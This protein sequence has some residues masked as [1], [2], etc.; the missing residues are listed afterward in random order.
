MPKLTKT[1]HTDLL[2]RIME[3]GGPTEDMEEL[4]KKLQDD[5]DER[6]GELQRYGEKADKTNPRDTEDSKTERNQKDAKR[7][8]RR[9][10]E[11]EE[12]YNELYN[13]HQN[14]R[15]KYIDRYFTSADKIVED[16]IEDVKK[17]D[18]STKVSFDELF[19]ERQKA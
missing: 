12:K 4:I 3:T 14:L 18:D 11:W 6:E 19:E 13:E 8:D 10:N 17:D 16:E 1:E 7:E 9:E 2:R 5:F 15:K